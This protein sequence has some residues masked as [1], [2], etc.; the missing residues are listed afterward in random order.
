MHADDGDLDSLFPDI[1]A[2]AADAGEGEAV[3]S[4]D[5]PP[6]GVLQPVGRPLSSSKQPSRHASGEPPLSVSG[7]QQV[8]PVQNPPLD[9]GEKG[10]AW[11]SRAG[12]K[13]TDGRHI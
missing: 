6:T 10:Q 13:W 3:L 8:K 4:S 1:P 11:S 12:Y 5:T 7:E 2:V 9:E